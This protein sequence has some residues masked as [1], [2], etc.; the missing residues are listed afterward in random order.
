MATAMTE[1]DYEPEHGHVLLNSISPR[2]SDRES[3]RLADIFKALADPTRLQILDVL[4]QHQGRIG[5]CELTGI[6]GLPD[7]HGRRPGQP[8]ISHHLKVLREAGLICCEKEQQ[9]V[10]YFICAD[11]LSH[12]RHVM[13]LLRCAF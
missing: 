9:W 5:A 1:Y 3:T 6:V 7:A 8:T 13:Q 2:L 10:F 4:S 12:L 11:Q